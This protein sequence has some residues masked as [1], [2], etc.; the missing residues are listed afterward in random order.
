VATQKQTDDAK[1]FTQIPFGKQAKKSI[2]SDN[3]A[4]SNQLL[5]AKRKTLIKLFQKLNAKRRQDIL[6]H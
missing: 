6:R 2:I 3:L 1:Y 5:R 4:V